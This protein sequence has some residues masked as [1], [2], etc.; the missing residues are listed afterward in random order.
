MSGAVPTV[1]V[2]LDLPLSSPLPGT[3]QIAPAAL[4]PRPTDLDLG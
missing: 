1:S 2:D 3:G 4:L